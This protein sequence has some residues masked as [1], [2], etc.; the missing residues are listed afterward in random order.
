[1]SKIVIALKKLDAGNDAH[2]TSDGLPRLDTVRLLAAD[3]TISRED[4]AKVAP[5]FTRATTALEPA[6]PVVTGVPG[7]VLAT[8]T[9][10]NLGESLSEVGDAGPVTLGQSESEFEPGDDI[11]DLPLERQ[12][13][14]LTATLAEMDS[15]LARFNVERAKVVA[16][17]D[18][19]ILAL[20]ADK[21]KSQTSAIQGYLAAQNATAHR[22]AEQVQQL[23]DL[24]VNP[25]ALLRAMSVRAPVDAAR[26]RKGNID[27]A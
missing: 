8:E 25:T 11:G 3:Q 6:E 10:S 18:T 5:G 19:V 20:E 13:E 23:R 14:E 27:G 21:P 17:L 16:E 1:M 26:Q 7:A 2:W 15:A 24:G 4:I 22:K 12:H 9:L